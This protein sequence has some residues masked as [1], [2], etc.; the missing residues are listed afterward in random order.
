V[1][2]E[3]ALHHQCLLEAARRGAAQ[4]HDDASSGGVG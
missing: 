1:G 3:P 2:E 4:D